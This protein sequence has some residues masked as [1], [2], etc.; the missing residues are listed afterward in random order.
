M[1]T[2]ILC[3]LPGG[4]VIPRHVRTPEMRHGTT[5]ESIHSVHTSMHRSNSENVLAYGLQAEVQQPD[6]V[7]VIP[8]DHCDANQYF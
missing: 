5:L 6:P 7:E 3:F 4:P 2:V 1:L 8:R